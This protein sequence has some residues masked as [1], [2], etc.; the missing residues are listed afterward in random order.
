M[1]FLFV[2]GMLILGQGIYQTTM[3]SIKL[4]VFCLSGTIPSNVSTYLN[5]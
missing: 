4:V 2:A 3:F 1:K 5:I